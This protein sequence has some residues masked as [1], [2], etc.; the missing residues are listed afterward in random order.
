[1]EEEAVWHDG[2]EGRLNEVVDEVRLLRQLEDRVQEEVDLRK[3]YEKKIE[4]TAAEIKQLRHLEQRVREESEL[5]KGLQSR[6]EE[7]QA[8]MLTSRT[9]KQ[10][11]LEEAELRRALEKRLDEAVEE[12]QVSRQLKQRMAE[13]AELRKGLERKL[14][15]ALEDI[16]A[17]KTTT[18]TSTT[19][20]PPLNKSTTS[21]MR[22]SVGP[23]HTTATP[24]T[25]ATRTPHV[26]S[27]TADRTSTPATRAIG[28]TEEKRAVLGRTRANLGGVKLDRK[29][30][31]AI[32]AELSSMFCN[33]ATCAKQPFHLKHIL[34]P[35]RPK[36]TP[37]E[38]RG[39]SD[40]MGEFTPAVL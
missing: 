7:A 39:R 33:L 31:H 37:T 8:D 35:T 6:L 28:R 11:V 22:A 24:P 14:Q 25:R 13:E 40:T 30:N 26:P 34:Y 27:S 18:A 32:S 16:R 38:F 4:N 23:A 10:R 5:R 9:L 36:R 3:G 20:S 12:M 1:M 29:R 21:S 2:L 19:R 15:E 17:L